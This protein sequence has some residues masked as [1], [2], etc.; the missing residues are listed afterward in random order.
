[1]LRDE[2]VIATKA[3]HDMWPGP[4]GSYGGSRKYL[5]ASLDQSLARLG[6]DY[7]DIFYSHTPDPETPLEETIGAL[8]TRSAPA[9]RST[10][11]SAPTRPE[12]SREAAA[13]ARSMGTPLLVH[14]PSYSMINR[15]VEDG[16]LDVL[17]E[18]GM[19]CV[20]FSPL[21]Q[22]LLTN[23]YLDGVPQDSRFAPYIAAGHDILTRSGSR[24]SRS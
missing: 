2:L 10:P 24:C 5:L 20:A 14:Q 16:L 6:L 17:E 22:G 12:Q 11:A 3:G 8:D 21:H 7:V 9:V 1:M 15:W 19:G 13:V 18:T 23:R 4:Y